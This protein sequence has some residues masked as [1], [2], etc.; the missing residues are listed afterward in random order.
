MFGRGDLFY[1]SGMSLQIVYKGLFYILVT[2]NFLFIVIKPY[3]EPVTAKGI[4]IVCVLEKLCVIR[5]T[6]RQIDENTIWLSVELVYL[7]RKA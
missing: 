6:F 3:N 2:N 5:Y 1:F 4:P 7:I